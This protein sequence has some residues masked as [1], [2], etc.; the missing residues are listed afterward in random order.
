[1]RGLSGARRGGR[2]LTFQPT[3]LLSTPVIPGLATG[4]NPEATTGRDGLQSVASRVDSGFRYAAP[5]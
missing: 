1:M 3:F 4:E 2:G 5:E